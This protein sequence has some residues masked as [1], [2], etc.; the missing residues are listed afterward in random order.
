MATRYDEKNCA[1]QCAKCNT[2]NQGEQY[3]F[4][5]AIDDIYGE[6]TADELERKARKLT[7]FNKVQLLEIAQ[8]YK[9]KIL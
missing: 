2:F 6:G 8:Y 1:L 5:K 3:L 4:S 9:D 7:K